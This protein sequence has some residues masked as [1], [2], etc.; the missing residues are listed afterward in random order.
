MASILVIEDI[1]DNYHFVNRVL[2][3][4]GHAITWAEDAQT[5]LDLLETMR[6]DLILLDLGLPDYDG[7]TVAGWLRRTPDLAEIPIIVV[8]AWPEE[9]AR[10]VVAAY[11]CND[12]LTKPVSIA[13][14]INKVNLYTGN[15]TSAPAN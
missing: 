6:P 14:L 2:S 5:A 7:E 13:D 12:Y 1:A 15:P 10:K 4:R 9:T 11:N 3:S 8:T